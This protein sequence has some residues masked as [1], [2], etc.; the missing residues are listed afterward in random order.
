VCPNDAL[1]GMDVLRRC[2][3]V[4]GTAALAGKCSGPVR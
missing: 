2:V 3:I 1:L 4:L